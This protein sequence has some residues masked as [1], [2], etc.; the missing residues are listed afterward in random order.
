M[1]R[2]RRKNI[3]LLLLLIVLALLLTVLLQLR[4]AS[5][6]FF[7]INPFQ[8]LTH[9]V[10]AIYIPCIDTVLRDESGNISKIY[11]VWCQ[12]SIWFN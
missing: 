9:G 4:Y 12:Q 5:I 3:R 2:N 10:R 6:D 7:F 11:I 1:N 8:P